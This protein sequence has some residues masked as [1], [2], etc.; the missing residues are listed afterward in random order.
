MRSQMQETTTPTRAGK[1]SGLD[2]GLR[3]L[4]LFTIQDGDWAVKEMSEALDIPL[5][6][7]Y[8]IVRTLEAEGFLELADSSGSYRLGLR[9]LH[10]GFLVHSKL[11]VCHVAFPTM[12]RLAE[13]VGET[14]VLMIPRRQ[15]AV[16]V[17]NV[18]GTYPIRP[19]S[20]EV[21]ERRHFNCGAVALALL[22][23]LPEKNREEIF[24]EPFPRLTEFTLTSA[25]KIG[26]RCD[27]IRETGVSYSKNEVFLG[28]AA[29]ASP[30][31]DARG[32][33][34][35]AVALTGV[36]ER[37]VELDETIRMAAQEISSGLGWA[38]L[39]T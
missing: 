22:A 20:I 30:V 1:V 14:V 31:F 21:G 5:S 10:L 3:V 6:S 35:A 11:D 29:V 15:Y 33:V 17:G 38:D 2:R 13:D 28:T 27:L 36:V 8:R 18:E 25:E 32:E 9:L 26:L 4:S 23:N 24:K 34:A 19:K 16:C 39:R 7:T 12:Q 37:I